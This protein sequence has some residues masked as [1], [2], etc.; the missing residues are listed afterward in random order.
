MQ[1]KDYCKMSQISW[2]VL[3]KVLGGAIKGLL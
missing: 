2:G 3:I 1:F